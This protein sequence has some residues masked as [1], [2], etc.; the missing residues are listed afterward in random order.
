MGQVAVLFRLMPQGVDTDIRAVAEGVRTA[1]PVGRHR[2]RHAGQGHRLR[3]EVALLVTVVMTDTS[4]ILQTH[5]GGVREGAR[6][7]VRRG[8]GRGP[9][10]GRGLRGV[11]GPLSPTSSRRTC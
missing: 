8:D 5:R 1:I 9:P 11:R 6:R 4:G 2:P 10:V 3:T 7:R